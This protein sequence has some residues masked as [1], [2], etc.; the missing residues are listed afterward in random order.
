MRSHQM[1]RTVWIISVLALCAC[2]KENPYAKMDEAEIHRRAQSLPLPERYEFF[3]DVTRSSIPDNPVVASDLV[4]L[5]E[6]ARQ[7][8]LK[9]ALRGNR[10]DL[11]AAL[12]AL[13]AFDGAC[14]KAE[15]TQLKEKAKHVAHGDEDLNALNQGILVACE[16]GVPPGMRNPWKGKINEN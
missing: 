15:L 16:L 14:S 8:V 12:S 13:S 2:T 5:G 7:Y 11:T 4:L 1:I 9:Q 6:P 3:L 10:Y